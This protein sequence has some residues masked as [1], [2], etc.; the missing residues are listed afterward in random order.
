MDKKFLE[1]NKVIPV[2]KVDKAED[3][4]DILAI[5]EKGD[6]NIAEITYRSACAD[7]ALELGLKKFPNMIIGA[8][9][10]INKEQCLSAIE[11]GAKF[12][13]SPGYLEE[14]GNVADK[15]N[16]PYIPGVAT[17]SEIM[18]A[19]KNGYEILKFFPCQNFG[20]LETLKAYSSVFPQIKFI[21]TGGINQDNFMKF[22]THPSV[23][24]VAG[25]WIFKNDGEDASKNVIRNLENQD[26]SK[27]ER[28][29]KINVEITK[30]E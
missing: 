12:I 23:I 26:K 27:P 13:V 1:D 29:Y 9:T 4:I 24:A 5:L 18:R 6:I 2:I 14:I 7:K 16:V 17:P 10:V 28:N 19:Y 15:F 20:G 25:T 3:I 30:I 11:K 22:L 8:G 21:P